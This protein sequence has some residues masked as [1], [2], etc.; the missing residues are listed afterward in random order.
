MHRLFLIVLVVILC[1][2]TMCLCEDPLHAAVYASS[3]GTTSMYDCRRNEYY[4]NECLLFLD[5]GHYALPQ[6]DD[7]QLK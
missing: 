2:L 3:V 1:H 5:G 4:E 7:M 6:N